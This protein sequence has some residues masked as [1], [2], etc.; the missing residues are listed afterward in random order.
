MRSDLLRAIAV[1][2]LLAV[3]ANARSQQVAEH[4]LKAA[5]VY[6]FAVF[7]EWPQEALAA[8]APIVLCTG[9]AS[10][11]SPALQSLNDKVVNGHK[12]A[13]RPAAA[14]LRA[15]H[16]LVL[17]SGDRERWGQI[18]RDLAGTH[19][20]TVSDD[21]NISQDG[22][23]IALSVVNQRIGFDVDIKAARSARLQLSSKLLRLARSV[24]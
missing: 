17:G 1:V 10:T 16:V 8:S 24:Q 18:K 22:A 6:N 21:S 11:L 3:C 23:M 13:V 20:L 9:S 19:V 15:C 7:T 2:A 14:G 5:F 12:L 4:E